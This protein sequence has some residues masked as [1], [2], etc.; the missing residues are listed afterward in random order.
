MDCSTVKLT[1]S[2]NRR[3][4][5][6]SLEMHHDTCLSRRQINSAAVRNVMNGWFGEE[7]IVR[8][9]HIS[10]GHSADRLL[11]KIIKLRFLRIG[12]TA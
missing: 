6:G 2:S 12:H 4:T 5:G 10:R 1:E 3:L 7:R 8:Q 9:S 11:A